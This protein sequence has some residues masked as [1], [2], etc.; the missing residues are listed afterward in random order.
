MRLRIRQYSYE[1]R[2][3]RSKQAQLQTIKQTNRQKT[4]LHIV[5][6]V[7]NPSICGA[8]KIIFEQANRLMNFG[9]NVTIV[10]YGEKPTWFPIVANYIQ[11]PNGGRIA[12]WIP[13]CNVI[14]ATYY[15]HIQECIERGI[16]PVIYF[17]QG[18]VHLFQYEGLE[19]NHKQFVFKQLS[20]VNFIMTVSQPIAL[21]INNYF[22]KDAVVIHNAIDHSIFY[23]LNI[24]AE[25][26]HKEP[27]ILM[28]GRDDVAFK[29]ITEIITFYQIFH[30][31]YNNILL[32]WVT[33][34]VSNISLIQ[35]VSEV[36]INPSQDEIGQLMREAVALICASY[37]ESFSLPVLEAMT[38]GCPVIS[39]DN[40]GVRAYGID[41]TNIL[42]F[43]KGNLSILMN[44]CRRLMGDQQL[45]E[46]LI[47]GGLKT[48][49]A[50]NW[51]SSI[52]KLYNYLKLVSSY[53]VFPTKQKSG[54]FESMIQIFHYA[55][56]LFDQE[57]Y[58]DAICFFDMYIQCEDEPLV[59]RL[60]ACRFRYLA[61]Y[62][63]G[64]I[65]KG[66][67]Y[68]FLTFELIIPRIEEC[69]FI[70]QTFFEEGNIE[71]A[72]FWNKTALNYTVMEPNF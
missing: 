27:F 62:H 9:M 22:G 44:Q 4:N 45:R 59:Y 58:E 18:D 3:E 72:K 33:P 2:L 50:F 69:Q 71:L 7:G 61:Y 47:E 43:P 15:T 70:S 48:A 11:V 21:L 13:Y 49:N 34:F 52:N 56:E 20:L 60:E 42:L 29:A 30:E 6:V 66:R 23:P 17:E 55:K 8:N 37:Y 35:S 16:A 10:A 14:I 31:E 41:E 67:Y 68:C 12:L 64:A 26:Q 38:C 1:E 28:V 24:K 46:R 5:Y 53:E 57:V 54:G 39:A 36:F 65:E 19:E 40:L 51:E 32:Y 25:R 63:I